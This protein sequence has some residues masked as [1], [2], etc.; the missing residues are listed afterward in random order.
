MMNLKRR[1]FG[2]AL[3]GALIWSAGLLP[4]S[5]AGNNPVPSAPL[6]AGIVHGSV[7]AHGFVYYTFTFP[8]NETKFTITLNVPAATTAFDQAVGFNVYLPDGSKLTP[9]APTPQDRTLE[10]A[11]PPASTALLQVYDYAAVAFDYTLTQTG[12]L[13]LPAP[14][15]PVTLSA[16]P[17]RLE[18]LNTYTALPLP[19]SSTCDLLPGDTLYYLLRITQAGSYGIH[20]STQPSDRAAVP[21]FGLRIVDAPGKEIARSAVQ[22]VN[23]GQQQLTANLTAGDW[24]VEVYKTST[25]ATLSC[26]MNLSGPGITPGATL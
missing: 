17:L 6:P 12:I 14:M 24:Y 23:Y 25:L 10:I 4:V 15:A 19:Q 8:S 18:A 20:F 16:V 2:A 13:P 9:Q 7:A 11:T 3:L 22:G 26:S 5:A 1:L 21:N